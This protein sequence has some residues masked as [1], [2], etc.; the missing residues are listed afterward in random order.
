[1]LKELKALF[2]SDTRVVITEGDYVNPT[3]VFRGT[4][5]EVPST[6]DNRVI[7]SNG[8]KVSNGTLIVHLIRG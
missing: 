8:V 1:M 2:N 5:Y 3:V 6:L 4:M 7:D